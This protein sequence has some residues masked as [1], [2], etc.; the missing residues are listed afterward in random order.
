MV[1]RSEKVKPPAPTLAPNFIIDGEAFERYLLDLYHSGAVEYSGG[2]PGATPHQDQINSWIGASAR[3]QVIRE[4]AEKFDLPA[5]RR[6]RQSD[7]PFDPSS[8]PIPG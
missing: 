1:R 7:Q 4:I 8:R 6:M 5:F 2:T 3:R